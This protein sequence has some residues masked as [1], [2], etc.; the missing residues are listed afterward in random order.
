[1]TAGNASGLNDGAAAVVLMSSSEAGRR[2][3]KVLATI[4]SSAFVGVEP[5]VMGTGPIPAVSKAVSIAGISYV[6]LYCLFVHNVCCRNT[7]AH[8]FVS[9]CS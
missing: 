8:V 7:V 3:L 5:E 6:Q 4:V 9:G 1:M 2:G